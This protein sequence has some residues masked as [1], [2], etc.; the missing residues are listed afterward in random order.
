MSCSIVWFEQCKSKD[1]FKVYSSNEEGE[2]SCVLDKIHDTRYSMKI[3]IVS[4]VMIL[5]LLLF[6]MC[7]YY[8]RSRRKKKTA[9][10]SSE[11]SSNKY[12]ELKNTIDLITEQVINISSSGINLEESTNHIKDKIENVSAA[13]EEM[14]AGIQQTSASAQEISASITDIEDK[15]LEIS[16]ETSFAAGITEKM[17]SKADEQKYKSIEHSDKTKI[18]Y[19]EVKEGLVRALD[20]STA[21]KQIYS[22]SDSII[23]IASSTKLLS[24]NA[25]IE[26]ARAGEAGKGFSVVADE[27]SNL[28]LQSSE[29]AKIIKKTMEEI[30]NSVIELSESVMHLVNF[31]EREIIP[32]YNSFIE[33]SEHYYT[34]VDS[35]NKSINN[36]NSK[37]EALCNTSAGI[38]SIISDFAKTIYDEATGAEEINSGMMVMLEE[39]NSLFEIASMNRREIENMAS[40]IMSIN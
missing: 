9:N 6:Y 35:F 16:S 7:Y 33:T 38:T 30:N 22:L 10:N 8:K 18:V 19:N 1:I 14:S 3:L 23:K 34:D 24:L 25:H 27:I 5:C 31:V 37:V 36:I 29:T 13:L 32:D 28:S 11:T 40:N 39:S 2:Y 15:I 4:L 17:R 12:Q 21:V 20:N 26:A